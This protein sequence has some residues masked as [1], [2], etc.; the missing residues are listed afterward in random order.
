MTNKN[1]A[2]EGVKGIDRYIPTA[3]TKALVVALIITPPSVFAF[4]QSQM[5][6]LAPTT[7]NYSK[8][9]LSL[10]ASI[11]AMLLIALALI[12]NFSLISYQSKHGR[13]RHFT[14]HPESMDLSNLVKRFSRVHWSCLLLI[15]LIGVLIGYCL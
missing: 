5:G 1:Y 10:S 14:M 12:L 8:L 2:D 3:T 9:L 15:F 11:C 13:T 7:Q 6:D 4:F